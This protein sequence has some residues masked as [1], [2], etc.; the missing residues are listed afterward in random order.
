[1][2][3]EHVFTLFEIDSFCRE[4]AEVGLRETMEVETAIRRRLESNIKRLEKELRI[5]KKKSHDLGPRT[6]PPP[7]QCPPGHALLH[8][9]VSSVL[10]FPV[11]SRTCFDLC[12]R[13]A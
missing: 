11:Y 8:S 10:H 5:Q 12:V 9:F 1:M 3:R 6:L 7:L 2:V 13:D 4:E